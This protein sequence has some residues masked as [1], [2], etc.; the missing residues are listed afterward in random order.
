MAAAKS[1]ILGLINPKSPTNVGGVMRAAGCYGAKAVYFTGQRYARA[2]KYHTDTKN[3]AEH[4]P[5]SECTDLAAMREQDYKVVVVELV[6]GATPLPAFRHPEKAYYIFGPEDGSVDASVLAWADEV[7]YVPTTGCMNL[8]ATANVVLYDRLAKSG[9]GDYS[10]EH[11]RRNR[12]TNNT[13]KWGK[14]T[15]R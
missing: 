13:A 11:I 10:D 3:A 6:E 15:A 14:A 9:D 7:V 12:D 4:I 8:A 2:R 1:V 5:L